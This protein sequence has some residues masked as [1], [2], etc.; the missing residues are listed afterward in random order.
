M[1]QSLFE[2]RHQAQWQAFAEQL[3][4]LEQG[5]AKAGDAADFPHLHAFVRCQPQGLA[6]GQPAGSDQR[7]AQLQARR[8]GQGNGAE[9]ECAMADDK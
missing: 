2:S 7:P 5:N 9:F 4:Q 1:K 8:A 6:T 3:K